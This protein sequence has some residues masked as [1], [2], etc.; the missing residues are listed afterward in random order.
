M[1]KITFVTLA[2]QPQAAAAQTTIINKPTFTVS[3]ALSVSNKKKERKDLDM[4]RQHEEVE[5]YHKRAAFDITT[6][7]WKATCASQKSHRAML[8][9]LICEAIRFN[10]SVHHRT[11]PKKDVAV[12]LKR[13][14]NAMRGKDTYTAQIKDFEK[15]K[16]FSS[17]AALIPWKAVG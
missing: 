4:A 17:D 13:V 1:C 5:E 8:K 9:M 12:L 11:L 6:N 7:E 14:D 16:F 10:K 15:W 2:Q 3:S